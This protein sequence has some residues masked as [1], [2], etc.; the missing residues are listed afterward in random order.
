MRHMH[1]SSRARGT[2]LGLQ[3]SMSLP[4]NINVKEA[5][6]LYVLYCPQKVGDIGT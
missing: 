6:E 3:T 2:D 1:H 4:R 5:I